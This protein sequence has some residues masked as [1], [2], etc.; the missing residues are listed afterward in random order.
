MSR[1]IDFLRRNFIDYL[2]WRCFPNRPAKI[3]DIAIKQ[4]EYI[5][6]ISAVIVIFGYGLIND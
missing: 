4:I 2:F 5:T 3:R 1:I 6:N